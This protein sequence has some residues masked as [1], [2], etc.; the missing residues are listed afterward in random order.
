MALISIRLTYSD[1]VQS[2]RFNWLCGIDCS[3]NLHLRGQLSHGE[4]SIDC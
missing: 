3:M 4:P 1:F 2:T